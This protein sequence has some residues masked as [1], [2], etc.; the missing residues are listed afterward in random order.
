MRSECTQAGVVFLLV[1]P[2]SKLRLSGIAGWL[3]PNRGLIQQT[4]RHKTNDHFW[5]TFF[6]EAAHLLLHSRKDVFIDGETLKGDAKEE[7]EANQWAANFLGPQTELQRFIASDS[8][9]VSAISDFA[10]QVGVAPGIVVGQLKRE[11]YFR[12]ARR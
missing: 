10:E 1:Q 7:E 8:F 9:S 11:K 2:F 3:V 6:H 5:F 4:L 12:G